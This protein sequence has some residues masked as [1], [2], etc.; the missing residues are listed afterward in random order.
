MWYRLLQFQTVLAFMLYTWPNEHNKRKSDSSFSFPAELDEILRRLDFWNNVQNV[1]EVI[2]PN[3]GCC[4]YL[5]SD[6][7]TMTGVYAYFTFVC[8]LLVDLLF[9][10]LRVKQ[11]ITVAASLET[12]L[13][14]CAHFGIYL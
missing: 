9:F 8:E 1:E 6:L 11:F 14:Y 12:H 4:R 7:R 5:Q 3:C 13:Q 2:N 10:F